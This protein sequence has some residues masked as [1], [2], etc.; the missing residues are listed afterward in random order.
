MNNT[1]K[2]PFSSQRMLDFLATCPDP[3]DLIKITINTGISYSA[4]SVHAR[5]LAAR[6]LIERVAVGK[7]VMFRLIPEVK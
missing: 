6:G 7:V 5:T 1:H 2:L 3:Q 4:A